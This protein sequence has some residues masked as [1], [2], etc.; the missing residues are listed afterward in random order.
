MLSILRA[1]N[2]G[3]SPHLIAPSI[4]MSSDKS[5]LEEC[6]LPPEILG[7]VFSYLTLRELLQCRSARCDS[8]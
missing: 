1:L 2:P 4:A 6:N 3:Y 8:P 7:T 5:S